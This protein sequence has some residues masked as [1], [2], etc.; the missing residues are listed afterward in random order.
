M[1]RRY[2]WLFVI[3]TVLLAPLARACSCVSRA[4]CGSFQ[5]RDTLFVGKA[6]SVRIVES[7]ITGISFP[8]RRRVY[9]FEVSEALTGAPHTSDV[10]E[11]ETGMG[12][13]DCGYS[14]EIGQS[15]LVDA[16][17]YGENERLSTGICSATQPQG[18][19]DGLL[20]EIRAI[21]AHQRLPDL[22]GVVSRRDS[23][24]SSTPPRPLAGVTVHLIPANGN[25]YTAVTDAEG[26]YTVLDLPA[27]EYHVNYDLP[28]DLVT[29]EDAMGHPQMIKIPRS[30]SAGCHADA[31]ALP[32]GT[33]SGQIV[34]ATGKPVSTSGIVSLRRPGEPHDEPVD[35]SGQFPDASGQFTLHFVKAGEY[36]VIFRDFGRVPVRETGL[37]PSDASPQ[38]IVVVKDGEHLTG[39]HIV[40]K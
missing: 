15:Y 16:G 38:D 5:I 31:T 20:R 7:K 1:K 35:P 11:I 37:A 6:L 29:Y 21:L 23:L 26:V 13:G 9:R 17:H 33:I 12:G 36:Q 24:Y 34:D 2:L 27:A 3:A 28:P 4:G 22:S 14:F 25:A 8:V 10:I 39:I 40:A 18:M 32:S 30:G 19:A